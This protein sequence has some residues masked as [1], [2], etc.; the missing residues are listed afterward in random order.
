MLRTVRLGLVATY[1]GLTCLVAPVWAET[2]IR[3]LAG[4]LRLDEMI[5]VMQTEG[6]VFGDD[7]DRDMLGGQG[8]AF[9][10]DEVS[11]I[12]NVGRVTDTVHIALGADMT[13]P[14]RTRA[15]A[16]FGSALGQRILTLEISARVAMA[17]AEIEEIARANYAALQGGDD[18]RLRAVSRFV[19][20]NDLLER[21]VAGALSASYSFMTGLVDGGASE[22]DEDEIF[23]EVWAQELETRED[24]ESWL[25]G[26]L[27]MAYQPLSDAELQAY[28]AFSETPSGRA[29][30]A[31][32]FNG[33]DAGYRRISYDL[34]RSIARISVS[35]D[36]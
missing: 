28:I 29:L 23:A 19:T 12:Y 15:A 24:T 10:E 6:L 17:Q 13:A 31:A 9:W 8:R 11:R 1:F 36:L 33:F 20:V 16:F 2:S 34:G 32:L 3:A 35:S 26:Y 30:N 22:M 5:A 7:L 21:N 25:F 18:P 27:L 14:Q 4:V